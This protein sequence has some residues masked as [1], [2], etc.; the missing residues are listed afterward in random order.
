MLG[1]KMCKHEAS[2]WVGGDLVEFSLADKETEVNM[3]AYSS[4]IAL[5]HSLTAGR[6][7]LLLAL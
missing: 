5:S 2:L 1:N 7:W 6:L 4:L 3:P